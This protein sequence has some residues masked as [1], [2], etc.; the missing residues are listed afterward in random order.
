MINDC[1]NGDIDYIV[2]KAIARFARNTLDTLKYV[3]MLKDMQVGVYFEE[4]NIDTLTW[5]ETYRKTNHKFEL[6]QRLYFLKS[7]EEFIS[8]TSAL[9]VEIDFSRKHARFFMTDR[10]MKQVIRGNQLDKRRP[11]TEDYF[12]EQFATRAIEQ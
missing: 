9:S 10:D 12:R 11:Y 7:F 5:M 8:K 6:K 2:T 4:E 3:R 1:V